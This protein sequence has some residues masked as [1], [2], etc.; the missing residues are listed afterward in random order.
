MIDFSNLD[1]TDSDEMVPRCEGVAA[2]APN[3]EPSLKLPSVK[4]DMANGIPICGFTGINGAGKTLLG[5]QSAIYDM[6]RGRPVYSS[7]EIRS[8]WGNSKPILSLRQLLELSDATIFLDDVSVIFSSRSSQSLPAEVVA[9]LQTLRHKRL[10][11]RWTAP[12]WMRCDNLLREVTQGLVNVVPLLRHSD[13]SPWPRPRLVMTALL[14]TSA[15][16]VD[17]TPSKI[18]RRRFFRPNRLLSFGSYNTEADTPMLGRHLQGGRC[19]DCGG[20]VET[21]KH[22]EA[23]HKHLGI[24]FYGEDLRAP[25]AAAVSD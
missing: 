20:S 2:A 25:A 5:A 9:L 23:R 12:A 22:S 18:M 19:V 14:D 11:V 15:G 6:S 4:S 1:T 7:V 13:G 24:P 3:G 21:P 17:E 16:K 8:P 10:T